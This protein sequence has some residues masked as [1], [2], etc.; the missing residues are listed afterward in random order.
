MKKN[1]LK[2][3]FAALLVASMAFAMTACGDKP[4]EGEGTTQ[5]DAAAQTALT[6]EEYA[7]KFEDL[8][9]S[10]TDLQTEAG[11][12]DPTDAA[13]AKALLEKLKTPFADFAAVTAPEKFADAQAKF[14]SGCEAMVKYIDGMMAMM[15]ETDATKQQELMTTALED[16]QTAAADI[17]E[18]TE[19]MEAA[20]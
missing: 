13:A 12:L 17:A 1:T 10:M 20:K 16:M 2:R 18:G 15:E 11:K 14:K 6:E 8:Q 5:G 19:L 3:I 4:A 9:K 7:Q